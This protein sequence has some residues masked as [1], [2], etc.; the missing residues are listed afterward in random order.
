[1]R[2]KKMKIE[3]KKETKAGRMKTEKEQNEDEK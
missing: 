3:K 2:G 1:M